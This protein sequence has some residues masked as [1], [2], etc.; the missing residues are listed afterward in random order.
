MNLDCASNGSKVSLENRTYCLKSRWSWSTSSKLPPSSN[1]I[2]E[3][4]PQALHVQTSYVWVLPVIIYWE[5]FGLVLIRRRKEKERKDKER[6]EKERK[7]K[8]NNTILFQRRDVTDQANWL[9]KLTVE[10]EFS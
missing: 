9:T 1:G 10:V 8:G 7:A 3:G 5:L 2:L 4:K 6:K